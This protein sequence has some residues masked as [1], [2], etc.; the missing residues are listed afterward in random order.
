M[1]TIFCMK[2]FFT[3]HIQVF[4]TNRVFLMLGF[5]FAILHYMS[6]AC[7]SFSNGV[8][9]R[10]I[11]F[12]STTKIHVISLSRHRVSKITSRRFRVRNFRGC[13]F[14]ACPPWCFLPAL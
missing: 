6:R 10:A 14:R 2:T 4:E 13:N 7:A 1:V 5:C 11:N 9:S 3:E 12:F 8:A